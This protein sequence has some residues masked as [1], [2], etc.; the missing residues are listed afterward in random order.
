[1]IRA[2][3]RP[4]IATLLAWAFLIAA[5]LS[6]TQLAAP[7]GALL[8]SA[9]ARGLIKCDVNFNGSE[10]N[11]GDVRTFTGP[12]DPIVYHNVETD[13]PSEAQPHNHDFF[14][15]RRI[16]DA[17]GDVNSLWWNAIRLHAGGSGSDATSCRLATDTAG[18]WAPTLVCTKTSSQCDFVGQHIGVRQFSAYYRGFNGA[19]QHSGTQALPKGARLVAFQTGTAGG[20][21]GYGLTGWTCGQN[22]NVTGG[23]AT[24]PNC[25]GSSGGP[26]DSLTA[27]VNFPSCW[28]NVAPGHPGD[29][30][31]PGVN[32]EP[33]D[34]NI[35]GDTRDNNYGVAGAHTSNDFI[36]PTNKTACPASHPIEVTQL[37]ETVAYDYTGDGTDVALT[38]DFNHSGVLDK[39]RGSTYHVDFW[40]TWDQAAFVDMIQRCVRTSE[41]A[42]CA[43]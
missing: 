18:Y 6:F 9:S 42:N 32:G 38:S 23:Q 3:H 5:A 39:P 17:Q 27:H 37:R 35:Y 7:N 8:E 30:G 19:D 28:N 36:Y 12:Y 11:D 24:I 40:N 16:N 22:S 33:S 34:V 1:M 2:S 14:G 26:G 43:P 25:S 21:P 20:G 10:D 31:T 13:D 4:H 29:N 15:T 41:E